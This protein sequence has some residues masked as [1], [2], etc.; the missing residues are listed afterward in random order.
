[1]AKRFEAQV[2]TRVARRGHRAVLHQGESDAHRYPFKYRPREA[3]KAFQL[4]NQPPC[5]EF[6]RSCQRLAVRRTGCRELALRGTTATARG[7]YKDLPDGSEPRPVLPETAQP[8]SGF[9]T[10]AQPRSQRW[11]RN[12]FAPALSQA[13]PLA[14]LF[15]V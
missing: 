1:L 12:R 3:R 4:P 7:D 6:G 9:S 13:S 15:I 8:L 14:E 11:P 2:T 10:T 5:R